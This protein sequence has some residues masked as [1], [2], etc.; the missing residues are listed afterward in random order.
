MKKAAMLFALLALAFTLAWAQ[1]DAHRNNPGDKS[2]LGQGTAYKQGNRSSQGQGANGTASLNQQ[3]RD[4][5]TKAA[6]G[7]L[8]EVGAGRI[9]A[10]KASND[11]VKQCGKK[12]VEDHGNAN[13]EL[14]SLLQQKGLPTEQQLPADEQ[15]KQDRLSKLSGAQLDQQYMETMVSDHTKD[16][17]EFQKEAANAQD[18]DV[19][20]FAA[21]TLP[22]LEQHLQLAKQVR[23]QL[24]GGK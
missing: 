7:G 16:V 10:E 2:S 22:I 6:A 23:D 11:A 21:K 15:M 1:Q 5:L 4:F 19:K 17:A 18:P 9:A 13:K 3:D 14:T 8:M 24:K 12:M 20:A